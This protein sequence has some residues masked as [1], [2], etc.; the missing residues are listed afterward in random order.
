MLGKEHKEK[1]GEPRI[2]ATK[3]RLRTAKLPVRLRSTRGEGGESET[4]VP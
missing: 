1:T 2:S 3:E 4:R